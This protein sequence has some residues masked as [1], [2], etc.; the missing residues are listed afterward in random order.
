MVRK[1]IYLTEDQSEELAAMARIA[2]RKQS[3]LIREAIDLFIDQAGSGRRELVLR[4][5]AGIWK[6]RTPGL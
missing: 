5:A 3:E 6:D 1:Q 4:K 2:G